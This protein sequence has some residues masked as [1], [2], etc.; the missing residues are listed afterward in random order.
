MAARPHLIDNSA[1]VAYLQGFFAPQGVF[2]LKNI[3]L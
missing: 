1:M 2:N 3:R